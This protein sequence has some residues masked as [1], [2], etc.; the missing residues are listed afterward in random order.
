MALLKLSYQSRNLQKLLLVLITLILTFELTAQFTIDN[1]ELQDEYEALISMTSSKEKVMKANSFLDQAIKTHSSKAKFSAHVILQREYLNQKDYKNSIK[2]GLKALTDY[3]E[4]HWPKAELSGIYSSLSIA[5]EAIG[6]YSE[7][8]TYQKLAVG[9]IPYTTTK[10]KS[11]FHSISRI[12]LLFMHLD[13]RD[14]ALV[15]FEKGLGYAKGINN[16]ELIA[17]SYNNIGIAHS[18]LKNNIQAANFYDKALSLYQSLNDTTAAHRFMTSVI[19]GNLAE[20]LPMS[21]PR[22]RVYF[23]EDINESIEYENYSN[24]V[25]SSVHFAKFLIEIDKKNEAMSVLNRAE[26]L[27]R[28][29]TVEMFPKIQLYDQLSRTYALFGNES[30]SI[31]YHDLTIQLM[32]QNYGPDI[33]DDHM[34]LY[35]SYELNKIEDELML[36]KIEGEKKERQIKLLDQE[37]EIALLRNWTYVYIAILVFV[38]STIIVLK[39]RND[40]RKKAREKLI[41]EKIL[42]LELEY[43]SDRLNRTLINL[44]RKKEITEELISRISSL[45]DLTPSQK[46]SIKLFLNNE[47]DIDDNSIKLEDHVRHLGE[48]LIAKFRLKYPDL[49]ESD[50]KMLS[51]INMDLTNKQ[52][53]EIKNVAA[54]S[55]K[56]AKNRLR[57]KLNLPKGADLKKTNQF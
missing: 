24:A 36:E 42:R 1:K 5:L 34:A 18:R 11:R 14:S 33:I 15:Y 12:G 55:V 30:K 9:S 8:I 16:K 39:I 3:E 51:Y 35:S 23:E 46:N 47:V 2:H 52:I 29:P 22:K 31:A 27:A 40:A 43:N 21:D 50:I 57:K 19:K 6:A 17:H 25:I 53:A 10:K 37:K 45:D 56:M 4:H 32:N 26:K 44:S 48:D 28:H 13:Q 41:Q 7:A 49:S 20:V 38:V 54:E